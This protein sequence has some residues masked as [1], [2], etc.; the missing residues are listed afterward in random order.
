MKFRTYSC[1]HS[2]L[3]GSL[4][5]LR[6]SPFLSDP[7][8]AV[9]VPCDWP[10]QMY[11]AA[12]HCITF[13]SHILWCVKSYSTQIGSNSK[14]QYGW[15]FHKGCLRRG[16]KMQHKEH[17]ELDSFRT[18]PHSCPISCASE[19]WAKPQQIRTIMKNCKIKNKI[20]WCFARS[21][22]HKPEQFFTHHSAA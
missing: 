14:T 6:K 19:I 5:F 7:L 11:L 17:H 20:A 1:L 21:H 3:F 15:L 22:F 8:F 12:S 16:S 2:Y 4:Y 10:I 13:A 18:M 9:I